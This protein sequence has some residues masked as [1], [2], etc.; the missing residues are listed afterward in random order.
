MNITPIEIYWLTRLD[1]FSIL[2]GIVFFVL[3]SLAIANVIG[4]LFA[5]DEARDNRCLNRGNRDEVPK[6]EARV[7]MRFSRAAKIGVAAFL[8][9]LVV[10]LMPSTKQMAAIIIIPKIANSETIAEMG[11]A[12]K[13]MV[14]LAREWMRTLAPSQGNQEGK[15]K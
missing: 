11:D 7:R 13:E 5:M 8:F 4:G 12:A 9:G 3:V 2:F 15:T 1:E 10:S 6:A 14:G